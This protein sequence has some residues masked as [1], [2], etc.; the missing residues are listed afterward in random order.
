MGPNKTLGSKQFFY[1][2]Y[3]TFSEPC[4]PL[5][6]SVLILRVLCKNSVAFFENRHINCWDVKETGVKR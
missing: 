2:N 3:I 5:K 4:D 1:K 6:I